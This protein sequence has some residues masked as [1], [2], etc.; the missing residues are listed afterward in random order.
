MLEYTDFGNW[1]VIKPQYRCFIS[2]NL[3]K[4][5]VLCYISPIKLLFT[6]FDPLPPSPSY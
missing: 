3:A 2:R 5:L 1:A 6:D 4:S